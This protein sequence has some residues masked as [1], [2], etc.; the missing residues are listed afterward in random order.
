M[1]SILN[2][3]AGTA[4]LFLCDLDLEVGEMCTLTWNKLLLCSAGENMEEERATEAVHY[5]R[6]QAT[7]SS[8]GSCFV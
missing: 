5:G 4:C 1:Y 2:L 6:S 8:Q 3:S 7:A